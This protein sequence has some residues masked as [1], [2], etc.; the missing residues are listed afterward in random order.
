MMIEIRTDTTAEIMYSHIKRLTMP[1]D[2]LNYPLL[3]NRY[4]EVEIAI[5]STK[6]E[7]IPN[8]S[9]ILNF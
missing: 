6:I 1:F 5:Q 2:A 9:K 3:S 8:V 7:I 4:C